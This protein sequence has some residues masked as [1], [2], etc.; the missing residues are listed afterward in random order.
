VA[1]DLAD[2]IRSGADPLGDA[3]SAIRSPLTRRAVGAFYTPPAIVEPMVRWALSRD[4]RRFVDPGSGSGRYAMAAAIA[5]P[6]IEI[7]AVDLDPLATLLTRANLAVLGA[8]AR[9]L[10]ADYLTVRI[11]KIEGPMSRGAVDQSGSAALP[12]TLGRGARRRWIRRAG[13]PVAARMSPPRAI[14]REIC[15]IP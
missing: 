6:G 10:N 3:F 9:V 8:S 4:V 2:A 12:A 1:T 7:V 5:Q 15:S 11:P 13:A 14:R